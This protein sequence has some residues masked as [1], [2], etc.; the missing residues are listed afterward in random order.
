MHNTN[1]YLLLY[2]QVQVQ[3]SSFHP[4]FYILPSFPIHCYPSSS[5]TKTVNSYLS[6][7]LPSYL[8]FVNIS[9]FPSYFP[10]YFLQLVLLLCFLFSFPPPFSEI[11]NGVLFSVNYIFRASKLNVLS[12]SVPALSG[13]TQGLYCSCWLQMLS[14]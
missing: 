10:H 1:N 4:L 9:L 11:H 7:Y 13:S 8:Y 2:L 3:I 5:I 6:L 12:L 14:S